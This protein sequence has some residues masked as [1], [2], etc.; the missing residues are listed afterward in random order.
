MSLEH[1]E[2][3]VVGL[4]EERWSEFLPLSRIPAPMISSL[5]K[6]ARFRRWVDKT[7][8]SGGVPMVD[9]EFEPELV[10][11]MISE[12][13]DDPRRWVCPECGEEKESLGQAICDPCR[14]FIRDGVL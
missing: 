8:H 14:D 5:R 7:S 9:L 4:L 1:A 11:Q 10:R 13:G 3:R 2:R 12:L 6:T